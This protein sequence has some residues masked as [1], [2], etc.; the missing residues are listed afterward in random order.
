MV[1]KIVDLDSPGSVNP[2][3]IDTTDALNITMQARDMVVSSATAVFPSQD[4]IDENQETVYKLSGGAKLKFVTVHSGKLRMTVRSAIKQL[5]HFTYGFPG[6]TDEF[7][8]AINLVTDLPPAPSGGLS[9]LIQEYDLTGYRLD[10]TGIDHNSFNIYHL[11][12]PIVD[13]YC[14]LNSL[15]EVCCDNPGSNIGIQFCCWDF[16]MQ[17]YDSE[18]L[19]TFIY[20][21]QL[22][23]VDCKYCKIFIAMLDFFLLQPFILLQSLPVLFQHFPATNTTVRNKRQ[24][25]ITCN[26]LFIHSISN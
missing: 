22:L 24:H 7:G 4:I 16:P 21:S 5:V 6:A 9:T 20:L 17:I 15:I 2:V 1:F 11:L 26:L 18:R 25:F 10:L 3:L 12:K 8:Q 13:S 14:S 19:K 23:K